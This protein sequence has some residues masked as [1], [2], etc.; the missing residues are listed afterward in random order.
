MLKSLV[1]KEFRELLPISVLALVAQFLL[2]G[3]VVAN[4]GIHN[5]YRTEPRSDAEATWSL[6]Y[7]VALIYPVAVGLWQISRENFY[8]NFQF[9]LHRPVSRNWLIGIKL[10]C[11]GF[12]CLLVIGIP[13]TCFGRWLDSQLFHY[14]KAWATCTALQL[15][16]GMGLLYVGAFLSALR[17]AR[18]YGSMFFPLIAGLGIFILI[19][20]LASSS[21][22]LGNSTWLWYVALAFGPSVVICCLPAIMSVANQR[23]YS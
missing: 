22:R 7:M 15:C 23:D 11:G 5:Q 10:L 19:Q 13:L 12:A 3:S 2:I 4:L 8:S 21:T 17:P 14:Q 16:S 1:W 18:W 9:L 20:M 6:L